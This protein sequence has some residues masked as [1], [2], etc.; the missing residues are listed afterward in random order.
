MHSLMHQIAVVLLEA[1]ER[2]CSA[3][4]TITLKML[5]CSVL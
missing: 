2:L 5:F 3:C 1:A 4:R